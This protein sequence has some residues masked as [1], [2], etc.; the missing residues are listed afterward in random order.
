MLAAI[1]LAVALGALQA[2]EA[3]NAPTVSVNLIDPPTDLPGFLQRPDPAQFSGAYPHSAA[4]MGVGGHALLHCQVAKGG[5]LEKCAVL[6]ESPAGAGFGAGALSV[7]KYFRIDPA[8]DAAQRG[9]IDLPIGFAT[10]INEDEQ[11]VTGP[12]LEAPTFADVA[13]AYPDIGGGAAGETVLH[14]G[15]T[16]EG[17]VRDCKAVYQQPVNRDFD[18]AAIKVSNLFRLRINQDVLKTHRPMAANITLRLVAPFGDEFKQRRIVDP[19]WLASPSF[20]RLA[21]L[22]PAQAAAKNVTEG[23]G[24]ADCAVGPDGALT[25]CHAFGDGDPP[26]LGFSDAAVKAAAAMRISPWT[27]DGGPVDGALVRVPL[28]F[29]SVAR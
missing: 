10:S 7:A 19:V 8:S 15:L 5:R 16:R 1:L 17:R 21:E 25:A 13:A 11:L 28:R 24:T 6:R 9:E 23:T 22:F 3:S 26:G 20:A 12:W 4:N 18:K 2:P 14:C 27:D 29:T